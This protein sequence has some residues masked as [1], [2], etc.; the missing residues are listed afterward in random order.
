MCLFH[1]AAGGRVQAIEEDGVSLRQEKD[2]K[3]S[4]SIEDFN[5]KA[6]YHSFTSSLP[7]LH[8]LVLG[9]ALIKIIPP[10]LQRLVKHAPA[11]DTSSAYWWL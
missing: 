1:F 3:G 8:T 11:I 4:S 6:Q 9:V 10:K 7:L 5:V 2:R